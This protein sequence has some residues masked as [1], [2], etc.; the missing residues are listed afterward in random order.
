MK[1][2][3]IAVSGGIDSSFS[4][5]LL[6][7]SG[8]NVV[9]VTFQLLPKEIKNIKNPRACCSADMI[10]RAK[11]I[12]HELSIPH[13]VMNLRDEFQAY[14]VDHFINEYKNGRTPNPCVLCNRFI[15]FNAFLK[16]ALSIG[17]D[18]VATG[19]YA[20][21]E[22][23]QRGFVLKKGVDREKDQSYFLYPIEKEYL[24]HILF[25]LGR[26]RKKS[27]RNHP[28]TQ[29]WGMGDSK[30]SQDVCFIPDG[31]I[32][33][34]LRHK[35]G[36]S[37]GPIRHV[38]GHILGYHNGLHYY[39]VGQRK[40]LGTP[41]RE[42]L[43]VLQLIPEENTLVVGPKELLKTRHVLAHSVNMLYNDEGHLSGELSG[44]VR[45]RQTEEGCRIY[46]SG[47]KMEV[48]FDNPV[49]AVTPGQSVVIYKGDIVV[50]GGVIYG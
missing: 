27:I 45:F 24:G 40:G 9:A 18:M 1:T 43:Y 37:K 25:P 10:L 47:D 8:Y 21:I 2:V 44:K 20:A 11:K 32:R 5:Y 34:F 17:A 15:K 46:I 41:Y 36:E 35:I 22:E 50:G 49:Y 16:K 3:F 7:E 13:Y 29:R 28:V 33:G 48:I 31:D 14:V 26:W 12:A 42:A 38:E 19:H 23:D 4:A 6:K 39:T 30:E